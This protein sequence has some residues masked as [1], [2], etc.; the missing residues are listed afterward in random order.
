[1]RTYVPPIVK[2]CL[3]VPRSLSKV[4]PGRRHSLPRGVKSHFCR[5]G[6]EKRGRKREESEMGGRRGPGAAALA[7]PVTCSPTLIHLFGGRGAQPAMRI[8]DD[9]PPRALGARASY[10]GRV[11]ALHVHARALM[12]A[13]QQQR[14]S[15]LA[16]TSV[17]TDLVL[18][19]YGPAK[20]YALCNCAIRPR[21]RTRPRCRA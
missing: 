8:P 6:E 10:M 13:A 18:S 1:M 5:A 7:S 2:G 3:L 19:R 17:R 11:F 12:H 14:L 20:I 4:N 21:P 9:H 15:Q 16:P